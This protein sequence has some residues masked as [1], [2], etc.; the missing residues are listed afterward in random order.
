MF[1][2]GCL[3]SDFSAWSRDLFQIGEAIQENS[4]GRTNR[5]MRRVSKL[6]Q[7]GRANR[8]KGIQINMASSQKKQNHSGGHRIET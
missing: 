5:H 7:D 2:S 4:K 8:A 1:W 3:H 6:V